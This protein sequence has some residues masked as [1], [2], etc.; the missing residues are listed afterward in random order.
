MGG[1]GGVHGAHGLYLCRQFSYGDR[2]ALILKAI[3]A[4]E[5]YII[6]KYCM[7]SK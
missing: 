5:K 3:V 7:I 2:V 1:G 6:A 4:K